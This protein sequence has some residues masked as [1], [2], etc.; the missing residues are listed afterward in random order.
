M[1][2]NLDRFPC[3]LWFRQWLQRAQLQMELQSEFRFA[4]LDWAHPGYVYLTGEL[5]HLCC[6]LYIC[7]LQKKAL[8]CMCVCG[9]ERDSTTSKTHRK[10]WQG[11][12]F[13]FNFCFFEIIFM[14]PSIRLV[15]GDQAS[16]HSTANKTTP[17]NSFNSTK[18]GL[19]PGGG[20]IRGCRKE[21]RG[22]RVHSISNL[23]LR[24]HL[25]S[26]CTLTYI[27]Y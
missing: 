11:I 17:S 1:I 16:L 15:T 4:K 9:C 2:C 10:K 8:Y 26:I 20:G 6:T 5:N 19:G 7:G 27:T 12:M 14:W 13:H 23:T 24:A 25:L 21:G 3:F 22:W 18:A